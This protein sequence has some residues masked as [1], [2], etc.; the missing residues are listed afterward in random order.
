M[1]EASQFF[2]LRQLISKSLEKKATQQHSNE[3]LLDKPAMARE[4]FAPIPDPSL[5][6]RGM[7]IVRASIGIV[8]AQAILLPSLPDRSAGEL[9]DIFGNPDNCSNR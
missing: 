9:W 2:R 1:R 8:T 4:R 6:G 7:R 5:E 3:S